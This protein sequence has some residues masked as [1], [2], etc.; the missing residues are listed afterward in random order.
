M[1]PNNQ[2]LIF[3]MIKYTKLFLLISCLLIHTIVHA[4]VPTKN[5]DDKALKI[6][7]YTS[8]NFQQR[9][10]AASQ[11]INHFSGEGGAYDDTAQRWIYRVKELN[12]Q[13]QN[14]TV[15]Y[16]LQIWQT[17]IFYY[18]GLYQFGINSANKQIEI[19]YK[20]KDSF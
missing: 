8:T 18:S 1:K 17:E 12:Q 11:I 6:F 16:Y 10:N 19:G 3:N 20:L 7:F 5:F 9:V 2:K 4:Q 13:E 14:D 15:N